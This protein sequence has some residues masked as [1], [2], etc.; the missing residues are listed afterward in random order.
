[1]A[2]P[3]TKTSPELRVELTDG[4]VVTGVLAQDHFMIETKYGNVRV[5]VESIRRI[6]PASTTD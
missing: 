3:P 6:E 2:P 5:P 1:L 4:T